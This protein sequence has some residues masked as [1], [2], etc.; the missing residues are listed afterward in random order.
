MNVRSEVV[1]SE[2]GHRTKW[3]TP[4]VEHYIGGKERV[5]TQHSPD[6]RVRAK[7]NKHA[8]VIMAACISQQQDVWK[9]EEERRCRSA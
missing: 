3:P 4:Y 8:V 5:R 2:F 7:F 1:R 6:L 9:K